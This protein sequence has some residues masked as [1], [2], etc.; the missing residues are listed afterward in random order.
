M[1][2]FCMLFCSFLDFSLVRFV[3]VARF[4]WSGIIPLGSR[5]R[6]LTEV[7]QIR[8]KW[9]TT[10]IDS[11]LPERVAC[12]GTVCRGRQNVWSW[13]PEGASTPWRHWLALNR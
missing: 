6:A 8:Q 12:N 3:C 13:A 10:H 9:N 7:A 1:Q 5:R 11:L 4:C 2:V